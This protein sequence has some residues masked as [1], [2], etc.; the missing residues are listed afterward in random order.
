[1]FDHLERSLEQ[2][3]SNPKRIQS[4][5]RRLDK[6]NQVAGRKLLERG[7]DRIGLRRIKLDKL[8]IRQTASIGLCQR[9]RKLTLPVP[10]HDRS[11]PALVLNRKRQD[12]P[13]VVLRQIDCGIGNAG[14]KRFLIHII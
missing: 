12:I 10:D 2:L 8:C 6:Y 3:D 9:D 7:K 4:K 5:T 1:M 11:I 13:N 14:V